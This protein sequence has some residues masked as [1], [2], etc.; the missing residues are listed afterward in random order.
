MPL[1]RTFRFVVFANDPSV[2]HLSNE[3]IDTTYCHKGCMWARSGQTKYVAFNRRWLDDARYY[4][5]C[6]GSAQ[7][8]IRD[9]F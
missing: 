1:S 2:T 9:D 5:A 3:D 7:A 4:Q 6:V 8:A